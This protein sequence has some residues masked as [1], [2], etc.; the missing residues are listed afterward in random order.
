[1]ERLASGRAPL[2]ANHDSTDLNA[3][4]GVVESARLEKGRGV[5]T[6]RFADDP[7]SEKIFRKVQQGILRSISVGYRVHKLEKVEGGDSETPVFQA[8]DWEPY[9]LSVVGLPADAAAY[10]RAEGNV[11]SSQEKHT[12]DLQAERARVSGIMA[13]VRAA[14]L[15]SAVAEKFIQDGVSLESVRAQVLERLAT[16][17]ES[18]RTEQHVRMDVGNDGVTRRLQLQAEA[19]AAR[20]GGPP[21]SDEAKQFMRMSLVD[22]ARHCLE[23]RGIATRMLSPSQIIQRSGGYAVAGDFTNLL[24]ATGDRQLLAAYQT[25]KGGVK[26]IARKSSRATRPEGARPRA[27][28]TKTSP[29]ARAVVS[30]RL[31]SAM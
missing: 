29:N 8:R 31:G 27:P 21:C 16:E 15:D 10:V 26:Q 19:L 3:V 30:I 6:V 24:Q 11:R 17:S 9:E 14:R 7:D 25:A 2:L 22:H 20:A 4:V 1:M 23:A 13:A 5:A 18:I 28:S 12:M